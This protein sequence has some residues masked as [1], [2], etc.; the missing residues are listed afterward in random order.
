[1]C[2]IE[3]VFVVM[4]FAILCVLVLY[5]MNLPYW[6]YRD[7]TTRPGL[8]AYDFYCV[9]GVDKTTKFWDFSDQEARE[10]SPNHR[11][12]AALIRLKP[13]PQ[14]YFDTTIPIDV[15]LGAL[16]WRGD[17]HNCSP[18]VCIDAGNTIF[19]NQEVIDHQD[20]IETYF[21]NRADG[22]KHLFRH[23]KKKIPPYLAQNYR[24][25]I[26]YLIRQSARTDL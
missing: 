12:I 9:P 13:L 5:N 25:W 3:I 15:R 20:D 24:S 18:F 22:Y 7:G 17:S 16:I 19:Y 8:W 21:K 10:L 6:M 2:F 14:F 26:N 11:L 1:M 4:F 23:K